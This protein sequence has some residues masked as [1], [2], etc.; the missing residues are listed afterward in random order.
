MSSNV[1]S[2]NNNN[3]DDG[4]MISSGINKVG[5]GYGVA[6]AVGMFAFIFVMMLVCARFH[7]GRDTVPI[8][9][10]GRRRSQP[11]SAR[12]LTSDGTLI[13]VHPN[14]AMVQASDGGGGG[15]DEKTLDSYPKYFYRKKQAEGE[16]GCIT[17]E[18]CCPICLGDYNEGE[19]LRLLPDCGHSFHVQ[20]I[21]CWLRLHVSCPLCRSSPLPSP[22]ATPLSE[23]IPLARNPLSS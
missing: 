16:E 4:M 6:I 18:S 3:N 9:A 23:L 20:C 19:T 5:L 22:V 13:V 2:Y 1:S 17:N 14:T 11:N 7:A 15:I 8:P 12:Q 10:S 21:D